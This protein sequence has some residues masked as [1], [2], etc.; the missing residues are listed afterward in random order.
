MLLL[1]LLLIINLFCVCYA[2]PN[3]KSN[4]MKKFLSIPVLCALMLL[5][6]NSPEE[7]GNTSLSTPPP[8]LLPPLPSFGTMDTVSL[9][10]ATTAITQYS[11]LWD[12][13]IV[14]MN[15]EESGVGD[16]NDQK[17]VT[18]SF[19]IHKND[20]LESLGVTNPEA[21]ET[22][23]EYARAYLGVVKD[24]PHIYF[25]PVNPPTKKNDT[26]YRD[27]IPS[28]E[29]NKFVYDLTRPCPNTCDP[30]SP[31]YQAFK[32]ENTP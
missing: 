10:T 13:I 3:F 16:V 5:Q 4:H 27:V 14:K 28:F 8:I 22:K 15:E 1:S 30:Y 11:I 20:L 2:E 12:S 7:P 17:K 32:E 6:C 29:S 25:V 18:R 9:E 26:I 21:I 24:E 31:L 23:Y 19:L